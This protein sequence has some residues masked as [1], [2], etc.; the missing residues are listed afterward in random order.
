LF[1]V[2]KESSKISGTGDAIWSKTNFACIPETMFCE[3][4]SKWLPFSFI[5]NWGNRKVGRVEDE[6]HVVFGKKFTG[7]KRKCETVRC[8]FATASSFAAKVRDEVFAHFHAVA[9][10]YH[11]SM[12]N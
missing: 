7:E 8:H 9:V 4:V 10:K 1:D 6:S 2:Y 11:S 3:G 5:F 12:R